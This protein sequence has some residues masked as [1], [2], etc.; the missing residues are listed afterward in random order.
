MKAKPSKLDPYAERLTEWFLHE[1]KPLSW[2]RDQLKQDGVSISLSRL[3]TWWQRRSA[4]LEQQQ[5]NQLIDDWS[6]TME[7]KLR[8]FNPQADQDKVRQFVIA[9]LIKKAAA[10]SNDKLALAAID[11]QQKERS[12]ERADR[13][14]QL[15]LEKFQFSAAEAA[16]KHAA[17]LIDTRNN[18]SLTDA[19]KVQ[20]IR[21]RMWGT[22]EAPK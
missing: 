10:T 4:W 14:F 15:E 22:T 2:V 3:S 6:E 8:E 11:R 1:R 16:L 21:D 18:K 13:Q 5:N 17:F 7:A 19:Q 9:H 20:A 12:E